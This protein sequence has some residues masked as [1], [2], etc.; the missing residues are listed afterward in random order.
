MYRAVAVVASFLA[1][2]LMIG[3]LGREQFGVW[4][5]LLTVMSW[6]VF[7]DLG[8][9]NG[10][11]NKVSE[12]L[13]KEE[14][15]E[16]GKFIG[17]GYT[18]IGLIALGLWIA[19]T[20]GAYFVPW[21][22]VFN[23]AAI[24]EAVLRDTVQ[25]AAFFIVLN[26]WLG[27]ISALLGAVQRTSIIALGQLI[28]NLLVLGFVYGLSK[29]TSASISNLALVYGMSLVTA[30]VLLSL[31]FYRRRPE[32]RPSI[33]LDKRHVRPL[34]AV[35]LQFFTIQL[36]VLV[37]FTT[38][39][40]LITQLFGPQHVTHYEVVF[41]LFSIVMFAHGLIST[42]LWSA[43]TD[44]FH[45]ADFEWIGRMLRGQLS[46]YALIILLIGVLMV[47][48]DKII[49]L[50]IGKD[51][52]IPAELVLMMA[53]FVA[54][55]TWNN[56]YAMFVNGIGQIKI[57]LYTSIIAMAMNIPLSIFLAQHTG[58]GTS[59]IVLGTVCS[60]ALPA[61]VLPVQVAH[62]MRRSTSAA[63]A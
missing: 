39:K 47:M 60:L 1:M 34:L 11:R 17:S 6:V 16:A 33:H 42:P 15:G 43:Y 29:T 27:L 18:L 51:F 62:L 14:P 44:A 40:M 10:L 21:Q 49:A 52:S 20:L 5:T 38:D 4:S 57:Q 7:F 24:S 28:S 61:V 23:T 56:I 63:A 55:S 37:I 9:G 53:L 22:I 25:I 46:I 45:R 31:W 2:P 12:A 19:V 3:Y 13:A 32:L 58:L 30:N 54:L 8:V 26:F 59:A 50:W 35:G 41:K 36:A 48:A